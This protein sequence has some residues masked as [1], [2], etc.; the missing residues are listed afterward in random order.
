MMGSACA[1]PKGLLGEEDISRV[2]ETVQ[3]FG[4]LLSMRKMPDG[5]TRPYE[6][7][8]AL[9]DALK[10]TIDGVDAWNIERFLCSQIIAMGLEGIPGFYIHSLLATQN[11][12]EG[13]EKTGHNRAINRHRWHY[14]DLLE[15]LDNP[16]STHS[17]VFT[18]LT[19]IFETADK[20]DDL[21]SQCH[22]IHP[23]TGRTVVRLLATEYRPVAKHVRHPQSHP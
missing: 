17:K 14:P 5:G 3:S 12:H 15:Q 19:R 21:S 9:F 13:V 10:G 20:A 22:A 7:N 1:P 2:I 18:A 11:D 16:A 23:A 4:G 6:I 8:I